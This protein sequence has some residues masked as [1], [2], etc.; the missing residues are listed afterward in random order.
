MNERFLD[1]PFVLPALVLGIALLGG[2]WILGVG[3]A[4]RGSDSTI[5]VTGSASQDVKAD[6]ATWRI[7]VKRTAYVNGTGTAYAQ[8]VRDGDAVQ[9]YF[10]A[11]NLA[12]STILASVISTDENY[13]QDQN[14]PTTY[15]V[16]ET[17][18]IQ[19]S[20]VE[21]ID[22]LSRSL[23]DV[24]SKV[25]SG[26]LVS[27][28]QP[29][30]YV[31]S[32]PQLRISLIGKAIQDA[33]ARAVEIAKSGGSS[34]GALKSASSGVVQVLAPNST[35]VDDY[36]SYDTSTIQKQVMVTAHASFYVR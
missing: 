13:K 36:G 21:K 10:N 3:I 25:S 32:L 33:K 4:N 16:H 12:S 34:V 6:E 15:N 26:T 5:A 7:D 30:Y 31:S 29:E 19:T 14:A 2:L 9:K 23:G 27:P 35:N 22:Q 18:T 28:Q 24:S 1:R 8:I 20:D 11:Q 17:I